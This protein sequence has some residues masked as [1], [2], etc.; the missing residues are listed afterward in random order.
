MLYFP[1]SRFRFLDSVILYKQLMDLDGFWN[2]VIDKHFCDYKYECFLTH[3]MW[4]NPIGYDL[5]TNLNLVYGGNDIFD[6]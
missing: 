1:T 4:E 6:L 5:Y 2:S 3:K